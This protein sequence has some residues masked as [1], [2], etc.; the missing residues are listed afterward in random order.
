MLY[1]VTSLQDSDFNFTV[2]ANND[3]ELINAIAETVDD[4]C[5]EDYYNDTTL[6]DY[7]GSTWQVHELGEPFKVEL[8]ISRKVSGK[9]C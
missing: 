4:R 7:N 1:N 2:C 9:R 8:S 6:D 3:S 5:S